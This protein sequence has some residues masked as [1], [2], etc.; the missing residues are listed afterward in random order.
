MNI[1]KNIKKFRN[2]NK[3][4]QEKLGKIIGVKSIT[5]RKY[6]SDERQ[7][8]IKTLNNIAAALGVTINDLLG[9]N[10]IDSYTDGDSSAKFILVDDLIKK[11][12]PFRGG[13]V[14]RITIESSNSLYLDLNNFQS[15]E[16]DEA[17]SDGVDYENHKNDIQITIK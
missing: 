17:W 7:P 1:G 14:E 2:E 13:I 3:L 11:L 16:I 12:E 6:E 10:D 8:D 4:T 15:M 5:I 9:D